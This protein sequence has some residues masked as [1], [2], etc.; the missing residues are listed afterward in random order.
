MEELTPLRLYSANR[1]VFIPINPSTRKKGA[2]IML[3]TKDSVDS[4][5]LMNL[6]Y[7]YNPKL[8]ESLYIDR[9][10]NALIKGGMIIDEESEEDNSP[11]SEAMMHIKDSDRIKVT[12]DAKLANPNDIRLAKNVFNE[13]TFLKWYRFFNTS[14]RHICTDVTIDLYP[15]IKEM[16]KAN[17]GTAL[18]NKDI[19]S[20]SYSYKDR[21]CVVAN[22][23]YADIKSKDGPDYEKYLLNELITFVCMHTSRNCSRFLAGQIATALSG[24]LTKELIGKIKNNWGEQKD[25]G[26]ATA[27]VIK[28]MYDKEGR[29]SVVE[30]CKTGDINILGKYAAKGFINRISGIYEASNDIQSIDENVFISEEDLSL[31]FEKWRPNKG[32]N[33]LFITGL[34]GSGKST[35]SKEIAKKYG[36]QLFSLDWIANTKY[37]SNPVLNEVR[38]SLPSYKDAIDSNFSGDKYKNMTFDDICD[39]FLNPATMKA[40]DIME[41][42]YKKLYV[43]EGLQLIYYYPIENLLGKPMIIKGSSIT[44]SFFRRYK[45]N[46]LIAKRSNLGI[47]LK[48]LLTNLSKQ[49]ILL[50]E[51]KRHLYE[52]IKS[53]SYEIYEATLTAADRKALKDSDYGLPKLRKY[54][55]PDESHVRSAIRFFNHVSKED[56]AELARNI[57][58]KIKAY[59]MSVEVGED[60]R[61]SKYY[62]GSKNESSL[63]NELFQGTDGDL[64]TWMKANIKYKNFDRLMSPEEVSKNKNGSCHDQVM[65]EMQALKETGSV[66]NI[67]AW[68]IIEYN[69]K[70]NSGGETHSIV[71]YSKNNRKYY[72][73][74]AWSSNSGIHP[75]T[76]S[77]K[78]LFTAYHKS[79]KWG[80]IDRYP[81]IE[82]T[83][84]R[85]NPGMTLQELVDACTSNPSIKES[86]LVL[87]AAEIDV[88]LDKIA[89]G[90]D[91]HF[92]NYNEDKTKIVLKPESYMKAVVEKERSIAGNNGIFIYLGDIIFK[93]FRDEGDIP[94]GMKETAIKYIKQFTGKYKIFIRGNHDNM[95]DEFYLETLGFTHICSSLDYNDWLFTHQPEIVRDPKKNIHGH[96][97]GS[98]IYTE[99]K[100]KNYIDVWTINSLHIDS[101]ENILKAQPKY[102]ENIKQAPNVMKANPHQH[103]V[104]KA[105]ELE[106]IVTEGVYSKIAYDYKNKGHKNLSSFSKKTIT[107]ELI[108]Q[109]NSQYPFLRHIDSNDEGTIWFDRDKIVGALSIT[110]KSDKIRWITAIE[111][112]EDYRGYGLGSQ[113]LNFAVSRE[114]ANALSVNKHNEIAIRMYKNAGF[115]SDNNDHGNMLFMYLPR[116]ISESLYEP[117]SNDNNPN[118]GNISVWLISEYNENK[119]GDSRYAI[120]FDNRENDKTYYMDT[121]WVNHSD[122]RELE[123]SIQD[124]YNKL[125]EQK[126]WGDIETY[127]NIH[128]SVFKVYPGEYMDMIRRKIERSKVDESAIES[129][130]SSVKDN[131]EDVMKIV[132]S[133]SEDERKIIAI[134][135]KYKDSDDIIS[136]KI[137]YDEE[138]NPVGFID[139]YWFESKPF[140]CQLT[141]ACNPEYRGKGYMSKL[142]GDIINYSPNGHPGVTKYVWN[143]DP[144][145]AP[146][147]NLAKKH[148]FRRTG[149]SRY[150]RDLDIYEDRYEYPIPFKETAIPTP[151]RLLGESFNSDGYICT[152][153]YI[154][155]ENSITFFNG[156][157]DQ[158]ITEAEK[159]YDSKLK[160]YLFAERLKNNKAVL[161]RYQQMRAMNPGIKYT[162]LKLAAYKKKNLFIDLSFYHGLFLEHLKFKKDAAINMYWDFLNRLIADSEYKSLYNRITIFIPIWAEAW[163]VNSAEELMNYTKSIN[164]VSMIIRMLRKNPNELKKWGNKD[165]L[166]VSPKG[167]F[168]V[169]FN[170]FDIKNISRFKTLITKLF[171]Q[172]V[173]EEDED[174]YTPAKSSNG[175]EIDSASVITAK[176]VDKIEANAGIKIDDITGGSDNRYQPDETKEILKPSKEEFTHLRIRTG[177]IDLPT[178]IK[179]SEDID[180]KAVKN[181]VLIMSPDRDKAVDSF[182]K[183]W[184]NRIFTKK[185]YFSP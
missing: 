44:R 35:L 158:L 49:D 26:L 16:V 136:R 89:V 1:K 97:H 109:Y 137:A 130:T 45:R 12:I 116:A 96:I 162:F 153:D 157:D 117:D 124:E 81:D 147:I 22:S 176:V 135:G 83:R 76:T 166:F 13:K 88:P 67:Q 82:I 37:I 61:F 65:Y 121:D 53:N 123:S 41:K 143:V 31:N 52:S 94:V 27:Y 120:V 129:P 139:I 101:L 15:S 173:E 30:L 4:H 74:N 98:R 133:L 55:M 144:E 168:K 128:A 23:G 87:E 155:D 122:I 79:H 8:Y 163:D 142:L 152:E 92:I 43:V 181:A 57:K 107:R 86:S 175:E 58:K 40:I 125:H 90:T 169:N 33:I 47:E 159:K 161:L 73:E 151:Q 70:E 51:F 36:A 132:D 114:K 178:N 179:P 63:I 148:N 60:N 39:Q 138:G 6:P 84:F 62:K 20:Y 91:F 172:E 59:G 46:V 184:N 174:G 154:M 171:N 21:I 149:T 42:D 112:T 18:A 170:T 118:I 71:T 164:P 7:M 113:I 66:S 127:P 29:Q 77:V 72:F 5:T 2:A 146:S 93:S 9:N 111:V 150:R 10:V 25:Y 11:L 50:K 134:K 126:A 68:F 102:D 48:Y 54:P 32:Y 140:E 28:T 156:M 165:I 85:G 110:N 141:A 131:F 182:L 105:L 99:S 56:E 185:G 180:S 108:D 115:V 64:Y 14:T 95:P 78:E 100:P 19:I 104:G 183:S 106:D 177:N 24:Q 160:R 145:N 38:E 69:E 34:S 75:L 80:N 103:I 17:Q 167:Y 119:S 3:L